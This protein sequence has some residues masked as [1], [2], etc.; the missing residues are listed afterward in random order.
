MAASSD[1]EVVEIAGISDTSRS[2]RRMMEPLQN[3]F[4]I[5]IRAASIALLR[6]SLMAS[7]SFFRSYSRSVWVTRLSI[8]HPTREWNSVSSLQ[9]DYFRRVWVQTIVRHGSPLCIC[10]GGKA[11]H[12]T[13]CDKIGSHQTRG[14]NCK[15]FFDA[16]ARPF[17]NLLAKRRDWA[18]SFISAD[19]LDAPGRKEQ[20]AQADE[21]LVMHKRANPIIKGI[22]VETAQEY[23][24]RIDF[25]EYSPALLTRSVQH[26]YDR[27]S[28][29]NFPAHFALTV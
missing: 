8:P 20:I 22:Q 1:S 7:I 15:Q 23:S 26:N 28:A 4:S 10:P 27:L 14:I 12:K 13:F 9:Q 18:R 21:W 3:F 17:F 5:F 24:S 19:S 6:S 25:V 11:T 16:S 2:P 29:G